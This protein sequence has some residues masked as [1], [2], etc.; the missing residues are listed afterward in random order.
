MEL[1]IITGRK[2]NEEREKQKAKGKLTRP[3]TASLLCVRI[4]IHI[5]IVWWISSDKM[6]DNVRLG[7]IHFDDIQCMCDNDERHKFI[8]PLNRN[9]TIPLKAFKLKHH[10]L[11]NPHCRSKNKTKTI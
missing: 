8:V 11:R 4:S 9:N 6:R 2:E 3:T 5:V 7:N 1:V 10:K